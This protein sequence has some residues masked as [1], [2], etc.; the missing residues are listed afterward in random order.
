MI[1][2]K[3]GSRIG[4]VIGLEFTLPYEPYV[5]FRMNCQ[6]EFCNHGMRDGG[7]ALT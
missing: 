2:V 6:G 7:V 1:V 3:H 4:T 5:A